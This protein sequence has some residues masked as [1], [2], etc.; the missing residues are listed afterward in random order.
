MAEAPSYAILGRGRWAGRIAT[1]LLAESRCVVSIEETR[2]GAGE[3]ELA[4]KS[5]LAESLRASGGQIAWLCVPPGPHIPLMMEAAMDAGRH[6]VVE[7]PWRCSRA[8]TEA[9]LERAKRTR[10][11]LAVHYE[12]CLLDK[13]TT[14]R[15][16][17]SP[18]AG[19]R[20]G[21]RYFL[22]RPD[23]LGIPATENLGSHLLSIRAYAAPQSTVSDLRCGYERPAE[24]CVWLEKAGTGIA[25]INLLENQE[26][27]I[28]RFIARVERALDGAEFTFGLEFALGVADEVAAL[29]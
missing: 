28:Q 20:F 14:W 8:V 15:K 25:S 16:T 27:I 19:L 26:P 2:R 11:L 21:G 1:I 12:Y 17:F 23:H 4:Y 6:V 18:G 9:L 24:R 3:S 10:R 5:R 7:K 29:P 13:V 22:N